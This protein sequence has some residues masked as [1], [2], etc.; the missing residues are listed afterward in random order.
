M[1]FAALFGFLFLQIIVIVT[2]LIVV[3]GAISCAFGIVMFLKVI[4]LLA[5]LPIP[6]TL[7]PELLPPIL[8]IMSIIVVLKVVIIVRPTRIIM[9]V[10]VVSIFKV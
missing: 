2:F 5:S 3:N 10:I 1:N 7:R 4:H 8:S 6:I 9:F